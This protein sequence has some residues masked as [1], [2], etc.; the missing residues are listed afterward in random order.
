MLHKSKAGQESS[1]QV[2]NLQNCEVSTFRDSKLA[3]RDF[4][5]RFQ[6]IWRVTN[7]NCKMINS[8]W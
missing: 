1:W 4:H 5:R 2:I 8:E 7:K 3:T 6:K